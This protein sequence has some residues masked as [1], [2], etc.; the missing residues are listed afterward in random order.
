MSVLL[1]KS[2]SYRGADIPVRHQKSFFKL[3]LYTYMLI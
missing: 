2:I 1:I 3:Q